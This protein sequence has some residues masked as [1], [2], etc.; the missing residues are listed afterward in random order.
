[1]DLLG[2]W[3]VVGELPAFGGAEEER[4]GR[5]DYVGVDEGLWNSAESAFAIDTCI[6]ALNC[7]LPLIVSACLVNHRAQMRG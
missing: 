5:P 2:G 4:G 7:N 3:A 6:V 1:V